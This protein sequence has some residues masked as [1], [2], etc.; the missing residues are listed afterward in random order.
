[1]TG[2]TAEEHTLNGSQHDGRGKRGS[3]RRPG[4]RQRR[5]PSVERR[6]PIHLTSD[7]VPSAAPDAP[8]PSLVVFVSDE[9]RTRYPWLPGRVIAGSVWRG[10]MHERIQVDE[11]GHA[12][13]WRSGHVLAREP[14]NRETAES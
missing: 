9:S 14:R 12:V 7:G 3:D 13:P 4:R 6:E 8:K 2:C 10:P 1:M 11:T 5:G